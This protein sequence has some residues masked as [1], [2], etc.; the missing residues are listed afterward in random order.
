MS[1]IS[2]DQFDA[3]NKELEEEKRL[4]MAAEK[5]RRQLLKDVNSLEQRLEDAQAAAKSGGNS[6]ALQKTIDELTEKVRSLEADKATLEKSKKTL[7]AELEE[8]REE[9]EEETS[10]RNKIMKELSSVKAELEEA[11]EK[12]EEEEA[13]KEEAEDA[14]RTLQLA[15]DVEKQK[16]GK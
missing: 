4:R 16:Y 8:A 13:A 10:K 9:L 7:L 1:R 12:A 3:V 2:K 14:K 11:N 15:L 5:D 6:S